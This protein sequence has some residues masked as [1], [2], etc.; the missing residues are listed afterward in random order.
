MAL[1]KRTINGNVYYV[2]NDNEV[3]FT[4]S[5]TKG[6]RERYYKMLSKKNS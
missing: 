4:Y 1:E 6:A 2:D 3:A 5:E